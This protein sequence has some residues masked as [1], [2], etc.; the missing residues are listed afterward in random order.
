MRNLACTLAVL[1]TATPA[2]AAGPGAPGL[3]YLEW[4]EDNEREA[5]PDPDELKLISYF[6]TRAT[7][8]NQLADPSGLRGVSLGPIGVGQ[9][10]GSA[11]KVANDTTG[12]YVEQRW[13]PVVSYSPNFVDGLAT[14]RAQFEI[15]FMW[16]QAANQLQHN[17]GGGL[18]ADQVNLQTKNVNIAL[19]PTRNPHQ[20]SLIIGTQSVYDTI[21]D[22]TTTSLFDIIKTG[23][24]L[25]YLGSD[26]TG[27]SVYGNLFGR[28][29]ASFL[30]FGLGQPNKASDDD[31]RFSFVYLITADYAREL[32]PGTVVGASFWHLQDDT[33][34]SAFAYEGLVPS[35]PASRGLSP[36]TGVSRFNIEEAVGNVE[37]LGANFHHNI[38]FETSNY[39]ASGFFML[40]AGKFKS[41][42]ANTALQPEVS[43]LGAA[44]NLELMYNYG[45]SLGDV[46]TLEGMFTTGDSDPSDGK[47][48]SA[49]TMNNYGLPAAV[50]FN[51]KTLILFPFTS[52]V[53]NYT[54][55]ITDISNQGYGLLAGILSVSHD[56]IPD[57]L[58]VKLGTAYAQAVARPL[59]TAQG[60]ERGR[61]VGAEFNLEVKYHIRYLMT[62]GLHL[63][64]LSV[65]NFYDGNAEVTKDPWAAFSTFTWYA[66]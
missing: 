5:D 40:N 12:V 54:G 39:G 6:F 57:T 27:V 29:K 30:P 17:Q 31:A 45:Q 60:V 41:N 50:W 20:L 64:Y 53:S 34:G 32:A 46:I 14:F 61:T 37:F 25:S 55:A 10:I 24:K 56:L 43:I 9:N 35:G 36:Y 15:D 51:H 28:W 58:N 3:H 13:I 26:A 8:T 19:Y 16:G 48:K 11:T 4:I 44:A 18:N 59:P 33:E 2:Y 23:Y 66:F 49:F 1:L 21:Y 7:L 22:P 42:K 47:F 65:G 62:V 63:A 52:T 38:N